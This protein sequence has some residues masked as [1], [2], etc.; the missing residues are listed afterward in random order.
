MSLSVV[1]KEEKTDRLI[2]IL[3]PE[4]IECS[5]CHQHKRKK[6]FSIYIKSHYNIQSCFFGYTKIITC[7][8]CK[9]DFEGAVMKRTEHELRFR[10]TG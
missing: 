5:C 10:S 9:G 6:D 2:K 4:F 8:E 3:D 1:T 7:D